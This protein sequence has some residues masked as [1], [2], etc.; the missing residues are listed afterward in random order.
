MILALLVYFL[1]ASTYF[2]NK[3]V[4]QMISPLFLTGLTGLIAG[5]FIFIFLYKES[6]SL[7]QYKKIL[8]T[9][10]IASLCV[11]IGAP[12]IRFYSAQFLEPF[13]MSV[14]IALD[15][16]IT[17]LLCYVFKSTKINATQTVGICLTLFSSTL[18]A[19]M[20]NGSFVGSHFYLYALLI[21]SIII[22]RSGWLFISKHTNNSGNILSLSCFLSL[23][24]G[25]T[26][27]VSSFLFEN[28][29][30]TIT[31]A[32]IA[33]ILYLVVINNIVGSIA[34]LYFI[35]Q[36]GIVFLSLLELMVPIFVT[37]IAIIFF[38]API[39]S[40]FA[41]TLV[42]ALTGIFIFFRNVPKI[43]NTI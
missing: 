22:N 30:L 10:G 26:S 11:S 8:L 25:G 37:L 19:F 36:Y 40:L 32:S 41:I 14:L 17:L 13:E 42:G 16:L 34:Y 39:P 6:K 20:Q 23:F 12:F 7:E 24:G 1:L 18:L 3:F 31:F 4:L 27:L 28:V 38:N 29:S 5:I 2:V 35:K 21:S 33:A 43:K 15:P 9:I